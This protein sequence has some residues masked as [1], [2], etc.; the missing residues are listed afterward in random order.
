[1]KTILLLLL[2]LLNTSQVWASP[3][4]VGDASYYTVASCK[5]EGTWQKWGGRTASGE[6][7]NE[8]AFTCAF[9]SGRKFGK[10]YRVVNLKTGDE[11][12][13]RHND[14]GP[15][16]KLAKKGRVIDLSRAAFEKIADKKYGLA[17]VSVTEVKS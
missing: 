9:P 7:F 8:N 10:K 2:I 11:V 3:R 13:V 4:V 16:K 1:M 5:R 15:N 12:I 6:R 17:W 14:T